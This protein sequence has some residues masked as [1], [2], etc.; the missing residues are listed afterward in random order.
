M[1]AFQFIGLAFAVIIIVAVVK[2]H[3][4][5]KNLD[6]SIKSIESTQE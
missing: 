5:L 1:S 3:R 6:R 2:T 4:F